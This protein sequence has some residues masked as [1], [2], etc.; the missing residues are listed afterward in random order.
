MQTGHLYCDAISREALAGGGNQVLLLGGYC[1][2]A[3]FGDILQ[4]K[5]AIRWHQVHTGLKPVL[6]CFLHSVS[7]AGFSARLRRWF[8][9]EAILFAGGDSADVSKLGLAA[10]REPPRIPWLHVY[11]GGF[12]NS[13]WA[14]VYLPLVEQLYDFFGVGFY[15]LSGQQIDPH[16]VP[17]LTRHFAKY[18]PIVAGGRDPE[19]VELLS[20]CG[21]SAA[22]SFD[23][24]LEPLLALVDESKHAAQVAELDALIH[25]NASHYTQEGDAANWQGGVL[26]TLKQLGAHL[27]KNNGGRRVSAGVLQAYDDGRPEVV[28]SIGVIQQ[29]AGAFPFPEYAVFDLAQRALNLWTENGQPP[30]QSF[31]APVAVTSSYHVTLFCSLLGIPCFL[32]AHNG[33]YRQKSGGL[34]IAGRNLDQFLANP[35]APKFDEPLRGR[36]EWLLKLEGLFQQPPAPPRPGACQAND[37]LELSVI[38]C[39]YN[40]SATLARCL[41]HFSHQTVSSDRW[42]LVLVNDGSTD[43]THEVVQKIQQ[44]Q[45]PF[46]LRYLRQENTGLAGARNTAIAAARGKVLLLINDDTIAAPDLIEKHLAAQ[47]AHPH[48]LI[49]GAFEYE[50]WALESAFMQVVNRSTVVFGYSELKPGGTYDH[51][52]SYTCNL[53]VPAEACRQAG[54]FDTSFKSY[55]AEDTEMGYRLEKAG[56]RVVYCPDALAG[57]AHALTLDEFIKRQL[58]VGSNFAR[59]FRIHPEVIRQPR[60]GRTGESSRFQLECA[61]EAQE[62]ETHKRVR[63]IRRLEAAWNDSSAE[64]R[65]E[66]VAKMQPLVTQISGYY[67]MAGLAKGMAREELN[68]FSQLPD[69][70]LSMVPGAFSR[71]LASGLA[72]SVIIPTYN[73]LPVLRQC[74]AALAAQTL[75]PE[76][77][78]VLICD[79]GSTDGTEAFMTGYSA[80]FCVQYLRD[81]NQGPGVARNRGIARAQ[82][83]IAVIINDDTMLSPAALEQHLA[84]HLQLN[85]APVAV[86]GAY[87]PSK[88]CAPTPLQCVVDE[89]FF[90]RE[91]LEPNRLHDFRALWTCNLSIAV[92]ALRDTGGFDRRFYLAAAEDTD[93]GIRLAEQFGFHVLYRPDIIAFHEHQHSFDSFKRSCLARGRMTYH[94]VAKHPWLIPQW[95]GVAEFDGP[96]IAQFRERVAQLGAG[97]AETESRMR[98]IEQLFTEAGPKAAAAA[99]R[100]LALQIQPDLAKL[101]LYYNRAGTLLE[102]D[103]ESHSLD[104]R[105]TENFYYKRFPLRDSR[106]NRPAFSIVL[107][108][109]GPAGAEAALAGLLRQSFRS[110][111]VILADCTR[112]GKLREC[113]KVLVRQ[114]F[115]CHYLHCPAVAEPEAIRAGMEIAQGILFQVLKP[116][117]VMH[118]H[119]LNHIFRASQNSAAGLFCPGEPRSANLPT[120]TPPFSVV[121]AVLWKRFYSREICD[122]DWWTRLCERIAHAGFPAKPVPDALVDAPEMASP[123]RPADTHAHSAEESLA[124]LLA[125]PNWRETVLAK[126]EKPNPEL[127]FYLRQRAS[128]AQANGSAELAARLAAMVRDIEAVFPPQKPGGRVAPELSVIIPTCNRKDKL[129]RCLQMLARQSLPAAQF[130]VVVVDDGSSDGTEEFLRAQKTPFALRHFRQANKGPAAARNRGIREACGRILVFLGDDIYAPPDFLGDHLR[131]HRL[132]PDDREALLGHIAWDDELPVTPFMEF[133]T[134]PAGA[135]FAFGT[136]RN[137]ED[138]DYLHFYT[139]NVSLKK[140]FLEMERPVF[141]EGYVHAAYEDTDLG[142]RLQQRGMRL[143]YRSRIEVCHDHPTDPGR[144]SQRQFRA[145]QMAVRFAAKFPET[146]I[147]FENKRLLDA[148]STTRAQFFDSVVDEKLQADCARLERA[149]GATRATT[150]EQKIR[151]ENIYQQILQRAYARGVLSAARSGVSSL[152]APASRRQESAAPKVSIVIPTFNRLDLTRACLK[153]LRDDTPPEDF[154]IIAVDN[155]STD[156]TREFFIAEQKAGR[157]AAILNEKNLG[158]A[159]ACN[160]GAATACGKYVLFLNNDTE[161]KPG[162]LEPLLRTAEADPKAGAVG[163][164]LLFADAT[165]Q[166]AGVALLDDRAHGDPLLAQHIFH[167]QPQNFPEANEPRTYQAL[168]AACLLVRREIF[169][170]IGGFDEEFLNGYEDVDLCLKIGETGS[171]LVYQPESVVA[172]YESQ[173]GPER[174][175]NVRQ[176]IARLHAKWLGKIK[177]DF[178]VNA[179]GRIAKTDA[180]KIASYKAPSDGAEKKKCAVSIIILAL[181]QLADTRQCLESIAANTPMPHEII[182]VDNGSTDGTPEFLKSWRVAHSHCTVIRNQSNRGFAAGNNQGLSIARGEHVVL[183]NNDTVVTEGWLE[184]MLNVLERH[185]ETG[186]VGPMSNRVSGPQLVGEASYRSLAEMPAFAAQWS[187]QHRGESFAVNRAV[188]FCLLARRSLIEQIGGLDE[189]FASGNFEDDDFCIRARLAGFQTRVARDVFIHHTGSQTFKGARIDYRQAMLR[190]WDLFRAKWKLSDESTLERGYRFP[191]AL[192]QGVALKVPLPPLALTHKSE[193]GRFWSDG[194]STPAAA[195]KIETPAVARIGNLEAARAAWNRRDFAAAWN[196]A[197]DAI[198]HRPFHPEAFLLLA[199]I[200]LAAGAGQ[201]AKLCAQHARDLAPNWKAAR[202]FLGKNL[203]GNAKPEWLVL[204]DQIGNRKSEIGNK[205]SVCLIVKNEEK[206][207][208]QCLASVKG[209]AGQIVVVD[210]GST[211]RTVEIAKEFGAE[212]HSFAWCDDFSAAR[213]AALEH[214]TGDWVLMLDADEE[215]PADQHEQLRADVKRADVIALRLPLVNKGEEAHGRHFVPRLFRNAPGVFYYSRIHEQVFPGLIKCGQ[216][217]EMKTAIGTAQLLHHGYAKEIVQDRNKIERNLRL[218][219]QAVTEYPDEPNLQMNL[220]LELVRSGDLPAGLTHYREAFRLM[221]ALP[222]AG[223]A[224]ELREVLLMQLTCHLY[225]VRAHDEIVQTLN[226]PLAK[227]SGLTA[228]LHFALGLAHFE[229]KQFHEAAEQM[230]QCLAKRGQTA[231]APIDTDVLTAVPN[232]CLAMS[233]IRLGDSAGAEKAFK[234][235]LAETRRTEELK[236]DYAKFLAAQNR[237]IE[238]LQQLNGLVQTGAR[239]AAAWRLGGDIAL[240]RPEFLEFARDWTA[241]AIRQL[242]DDGVVVAQRAET[243]LLSQDS[244]AALPLW[245]S[246]INGERPPRALA[247]QIIC[248]TATAQPAKKLQNAAEEAAVSRAFVDWYRRLVTAGASDT[249]VH[250]NTRVEMLRPILPSAAGVLDGV[251][252]ATRESRTA[253]RAAA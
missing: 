184:G 47:K 143:R 81:K 65:G 173:S 80:P 162:W 42:E 220:G 8:G 232:H 72:L 177:P 248:A 120:G 195:K 140:K 33:Y 154:D 237:P 14:P 60:W 125:A 116:G 68:S 186:A 126:M 37:E 182:I 93:L 71:E 76:R 69:R 58:N 250:L 136:I 222:P 113:A 190:N 131:H 105:F 197:S 122:A 130:E 28:D 178:I 3:N 6:V 141:D 43:D 223:V 97:A 40:R 161:V 91:D 70:R 95:F 192:P 252:A 203:K 114:S 67:W 165:I 142:H 117:A 157:L 111:E 212:V 148:A 127:I 4:L 94:L 12:L 196:A 83:K 27:E 129:L 171:L 17:E 179:D 39:S 121:R 150:P 61:V 221:S 20:R 233:L 134:G 73:R 107:P 245:T 215:L 236:L 46:Q 253:G 118:E 187:V 149:G 112:D 230:R 217:W 219:R 54:G 227:N 57:H 147:A 158:F 249:I 77:F 31:R 51:M 64:K 123:A 90:Q 231:L 23:D 137:P 21:V 79:D 155:A 36:E 59:F 98:A 22:Y 109:A 55:G 88:K 145:G 211:D 62:K 24:A 181:N 224:P 241:E 85:N 5:G 78:E 119:F 74:L 15:A 35:T 246:A 19:S 108:V 239:N 135:Q 242:P 199:E 209:I 146:S 34:G 7:D 238:A 86:M 204:P 174:F 185:P 13:Y 124:M 66:I 103:R 229:L 168:T 193:A 159:R 216:A 172:H 44:G 251:I 49:L 110:W 163:A 225:K 188:G 243:L 160:Q 16:I 84:C 191:T 210:T 166:H 202:Q 206:F 200:A 234:A 10:L 176:N 25:L 87:W 183:L 164:K 99:A 75:A 50:P 106:A 247:A 170:K 167:G 52:F 207:L 1:G 29:L 133:I 53:S 180:G 32:Q 18:R 104:A 235:G 144:F 218:L 63:E 100:R 175:R 138:V 226:S 205:L 132:F 2:Y 26:A 240:S 194:I 45:L 102:L 128:A 82:G 208:P 96:G 139:S 92:Q 201:G 151:L 156:G 41:E 56:Y 228:S 169:Q 9:V 153:A 115:R 213:N 214:A 189:R 11:G 89:L 198:A 48:S 38:L 101:C 30:A 244:A 152:E